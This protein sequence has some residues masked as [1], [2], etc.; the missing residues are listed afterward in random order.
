MINA[1]ARSCWTSVGHQHTKTIRKH[2]KHIHKNIKNGATTIRR[3]LLDTAGTYKPSDQPWIPRVRKKQTKHVSPCLELNQNP[4]SRCK[5]KES[6]P[7]K[8]YTTTKPVLGNPLWV[9]FMYRVTNLLAGINKLPT[10]IQDS[11]TPPP[12][13]GDNLTC[14]VPAM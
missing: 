2:K 1:E 3:V 6:K 7:Q 13:A 4:L 8:H 9:H 11:T 12:P 10:G 5:N 14:S